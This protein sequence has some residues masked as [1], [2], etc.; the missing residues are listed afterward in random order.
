MA[1]FLHIKGTHRHIEN[2]ITP[3]FKIVKDAGLVEST[4]R[5]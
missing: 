2:S 4:L 1:I 5:L 3:D